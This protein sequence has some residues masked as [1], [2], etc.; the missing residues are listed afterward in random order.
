MRVAILLTLFLFLGEARG[1]V[2][3]PPGPRESRIATVIVELVK[4]VTGL[5]EPPW[6]FA[7]R[8]QL[9][10]ALRSVDKR[11]RE[12]RYWRVDFFGNG[13]PGDEDAETSSRQSV[14]V[15]DPFHGQ[16]SGIDWFYL[17]ISVTRIARAPLPSEESWHPPIK[18]PKDGHP[19]LHL[20]R[21][22]GGYRAEIV[23]WH[24]TRSEKKIVDTLLRSTVDACLAEAP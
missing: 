16:R 14:V 22:K 3:T 19:D 9:D 21:Y 20:V 2:S 8:T 17:R 1:D 7:C 15:N 11:E 18:K 5:I 23:V 6:A 4:W 24:A 12:F 13:P 10:R